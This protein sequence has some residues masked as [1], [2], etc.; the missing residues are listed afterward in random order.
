MRPRNFNLLSVGVGGQGVISTL[1]ILTWAAHLD[2]QTVRTGETHGMAQRGGSVEG[3]LRFGS[4]VHSPLMPRGVAHIMIAYEPIESLRR[5][6]YLGYN[7]LVL[8]S[9]RVVLPSS[10]F[11]KSI[12]IYP[13]L[14]EIKTNLKKISKNVF[15]INSYEMAEKT[16]NYR[17]SNIIM[18]GIL[19]GLGSKVL[20]IK[21][22]NLLTAILR[23][24]PKKSLESNKVAFQ[25]GINKGISIRGCLK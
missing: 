8:V 2:G 16:G 20:P 9:D 7:T 1:Q 15:F 5:R 13:K 19:S 25:M 23:Y 6:E 3:Y 21:R 22:E 12:N 18:L 4:D 11:Q 10:V 24:V 14:S 17:A